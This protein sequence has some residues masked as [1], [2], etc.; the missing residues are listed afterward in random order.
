MSQN[1]PPIAPPASPDALPAPAAEITPGMVLA[2]KQT[3]P[4]VLFLA[5]MGFIGSGC[6]FM[7]GLFMMAGSGFMRMIQPRGPLSGTVIV[8][9]IGVLYLVLSVVY[10]G[11]AVWLIRYSGAIRRMLTVD[12]TG[13]MEA[14]L[15]N[16]KSFWKYAGILTLGLLVAYILALCFFLLFAVSH[17]AR[18]GS[19]I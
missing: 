10:L 9:L 1:E 15:R 16:Q 17:A 12:R 14:A 7:L 3:R 8:A 4:W 18:Q 13:G 6:L 2:L 5:I 11:A 19:M